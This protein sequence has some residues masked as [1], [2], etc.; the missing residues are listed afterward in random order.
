M[1]TP[2]TL[3]PT[4]SW[5]VPSA[6]PPPP[7]WHGSPP[8]APAPPAVPA[9]GSRRSRLVT[10][11][12]T[13]GTVLVLV[14]LGAALTTTWADL[15]PAMKAVLLLAAAAGLSVASSFTERHPSLARL[16]GLAWIAASGLLA[17]AVWLL[18]NSVV[19]NADRLATALA[20]GAAAFHG[21]GRWL[22]RPA[23]VPAQIATFAALVYAVG[24]PGGEVASGWSVDAVP[25]VLYPFVG[26][27]WPFDQHAE[28]VMSGAG[29]ALL[30]LAW[31]AIV[32]WQA[33]LGNAAGRV[34]ARTLALSA[35][36]YAA[37][38]L[39]VVPD[40]A[41]AVGALA[42]VL[43]ALIA[44]ITQDDEPLVVAGAVGLVFAGLRVL[45]ALFS[46]EALVI[47]L[48]LAVGLALLVLALY[49][50]RRSTGGAAGSGD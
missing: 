8:A 20:G 7:S 14:A 34:A 49:L 33:A 46:G 42:L 23:D 2:T 28:Y 45:A 1:S 18:S 16:A 29:H 50:A 44:G 35:A 3:P 38:E 31:L 21:A 47:A 25:R 19:T 5:S 37:L 4:Q 17:G 12:A 40:P 36:G 39:T 24:P 26:F 11:L 30:G 13:A 22:R 9:P 6:S 15:A 43:A 27:F 41:W 48:V 10:S 32:R